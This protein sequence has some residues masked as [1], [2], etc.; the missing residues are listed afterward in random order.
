MLAKPWKN[1]EKHL[2]EKLTTWPHLNWLSRTLKQWLTYSAQQVLMC[3]LVRS[4]TENFMYIFCLSFHISTLPLSRNIFWLLLNVLLAEKE[5]IKCHDPVNA[6]KHLGFSLFYF[7]NSLSHKYTNSCSF[8]GCYT[9]LNAS[10]F[11]LS[12]LF[13]NLFSA[14]AEFFVSRCCCHFVTPSSLCCC[15]GL[16]HAYFITSWDGTEKGLRLLVHTSDSTLFTF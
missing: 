6:C 14:L 16:C 2:K 3:L 13:A 10:L 1:P 9:P 4:L 15:A 11:L 5:K 7:S 12:T 8:T